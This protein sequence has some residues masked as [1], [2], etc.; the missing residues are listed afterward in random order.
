MPTFDDLD[1]SF[2]KGNNAEFSKIISKFK[3][4]NGLQNDEPL[5]VYLTRILGSDDASGKEEIFKTLVSMGAKLDVKDGREKTPLSNLAFNNN[6]RYFKLLVELGADINYSGGGES[7]IERAIRSNDSIEVAKYIL[8][9]TSYIPAP[10]GVLTDVAKRS[11]AKKSI[12]LLKELK[13]K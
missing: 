2:E 7:P 10:T 4:I 1:E 9:H 12:T 3:D 13:I 11:G 5:L 6:L 8:T